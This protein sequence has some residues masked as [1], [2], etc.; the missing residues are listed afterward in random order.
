[1]DAQIKQKL[2]LL[3]TGLLAG[4]VAGG[5]IWGGE[6]PKAETQTV[7]VERTVRVEVEK[8]VTVAVERT[9]T[10]TQYLTANQLTTVTETKPD[11]TVIMTQNAYGLG[12][13]TSAQENYSLNLHSSENVVLSGSEAVSAS[14]MSVGIGRINYLGLYAFVDPLNLLSFDYKTNFVLEY[15]RR[16]NGSPFS[17]SLLA[18]PKVIGLGLGVEF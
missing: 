1:M 7:T 18:G 5:F 9:V 15:K 13:S 3:A 16:L 8:V 12:V 14:Q 10:V 6:E 2:G 4:L 17:F 11:G